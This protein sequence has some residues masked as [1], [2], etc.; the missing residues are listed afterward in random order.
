MKIYSGAES[1][2]KT[3]YVLFIEFILSN[4]DD[5]RFDVDDVRIRSSTIGSL[6]NATNQHEMVSLHNRR[7]DDVSVYVRLPIDIGHRT[8]VLRAQGM[9]SEP[10]LFGRNLQQ[11]DP[12]R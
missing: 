5:G 6:T 7:A 2:A 10:Q 1:R 9:S 12:V 11:S 8:S 4:L 3:K